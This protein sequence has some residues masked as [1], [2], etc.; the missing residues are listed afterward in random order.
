MPSLATTYKFTINIITFPSNLNR[1]N[2]KTIEH[3]KHYIYRLKHIL[4]PSSLATK[5]VPKVYKFNTFKHYVFM[6]VNFHRFN[7][8]FKN[9]L[10]T[11]Q[12]YIMKIN[13]DIFA[14]YYYKHYAINHSVFNIFHIKR[15]RT[16][17]Q[18][19]LI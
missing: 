2:L 5:Q 19:V 14:F 12:L 18:Q 3:I 10:E 9:C 11:L 15:Q 4:T 13:I 7:C 1:I 17:L 6:Q 8:I 16:I